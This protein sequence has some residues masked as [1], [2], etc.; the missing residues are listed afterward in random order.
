MFVYI[1]LTLGSILVLIFG[2]KSG[3]LNFNKA[4]I[5]EYNEVLANREVAR[6]SEKYKN[7][8]I[9]DDELAKAVGS[10][11]K[12]EDLDESEVIEIET[13]LKDGVLEITAGP[14]KL[15]VNIF[16]PIKAED[17]DNLIEDD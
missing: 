1:V 16:E 3:Y 10:S 13:E 7:L 9:Y 12:I 17:A 14:K 15:T 11:I 5:E 6:M 2:S 8:E 4:L